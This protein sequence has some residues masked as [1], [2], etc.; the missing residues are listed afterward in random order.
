MNPES[1]ESGESATACA[2]AH[3]HTRTPA[4]P[5]QPAQALASPNPGASPK[6]SNKM[7]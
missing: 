4:H 6:P 3:P 7:L 2:P 5:N 1:G